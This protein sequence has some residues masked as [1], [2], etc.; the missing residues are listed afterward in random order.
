VSVVHQSVQDGIGEGW[1]VGSECRM[2]VLNGELG[3][4]DGGAQLP[5][6]VDDLQ[7]I[8]G[9]NNEAGRGDQK[10]IQHEDADLG[11]CASLRT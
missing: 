9:L 8:L 4:Y 5:A 1:V 3:D 2:P 6:V 10:V 11:D 7:Q